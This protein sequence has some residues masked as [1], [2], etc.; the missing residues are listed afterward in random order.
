MR[1]IIFGATGMVGKGVLLECLRDERV[2]H[3]LAV[4]I[5]TL[6]R[7][8]GPRRSWIA[9]G[10][11]RCSSSAGVSSTALWNQPDDV[12]NTARRHPRA[13]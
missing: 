1:V 8:V 9:P 11:P 2:T 6:G 5:G 3:V 13:G 4:D 10:E 12:P 7:A